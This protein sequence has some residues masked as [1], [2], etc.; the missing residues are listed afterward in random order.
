MT[1]LSDAQIFVGLHPLTTGHEVDKLQRWVQG[2]TGLVVVLP[3]LDLPGARQGRFVLPAGTEK[4]F[5]A[6]ARTQL[7]S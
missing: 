1:P 7:C 4:L 5:V 3:D 2:R 6:D